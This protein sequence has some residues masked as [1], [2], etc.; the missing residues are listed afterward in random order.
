MTRRYTMKG[1]LLFVLMILITIGFWGCEV[2]IGPPYGR[3]AVAPGAPPAA[4]VIPAQP[5]LVFLP[6][7]GIYVAAD[8]EPYLFYDGSV[9]FY[10]REGVWYR[11][12]GYNGP[13]AV[14][15]RGLPPGLAKVPPGQLRERAF[16]LKGDEFEEHDHGRRG[17]GRPFDE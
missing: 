2:V 14:V 10:F 6:E 12:R 3:V 15:E 11:G 7:Y 1:Y 5:R 9:W 16:K 17:R 8:V 4:V 13:W